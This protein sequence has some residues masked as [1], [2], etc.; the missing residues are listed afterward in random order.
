MRVPQVSER[1]KELPAQALRGVF[2][3]VGQVLL[4][5]DRLRNKTAAGPPARRPERPE[6]A[7]DAPT[8]GQQAPAAR[9][10]DQTGNVRLL[11]DAGAGADGA[12]RAA[13]ATAQAAGVPAAAEVPV[14]AEVPVAAEVLVTAEVPAVAEVPVPEAG[15]GADADAG[16]QAARATAPSAGKPDIPLPN[17][18]ELSIASL[19][20]RLRN[21]DITQ[22]RQLAEYER[23]HAARADVIGMLERRIVKLE[24]E[25]NEDAPAEAGGQA[26]AEAQEKADTEAQ[27]EAQEEVAADVR[28]EVQGEAE[29][30]A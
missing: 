14:T 12:A 9:D 6:T 2:A 30:E 10:L 21:L 26:Q 28:E 20:A 5:T 15:P 4:I 29:E 11:G 23:A 24:A 16:A 1:V 19:R 3:G 13:D 17:Y 22:V 18:D 27:V 7:A 25:E 8:P